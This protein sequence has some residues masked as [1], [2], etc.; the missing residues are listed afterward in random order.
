ME[1]V[2]NLLRSVAISRKSV[3]VCSFTKQMLLRNKY[4]QCVNKSMSAGEEVGKN[5]EIKGEHPHSPA[6]REALDVSVSGDDQ[7]VR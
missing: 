4:W 1:S 7:R 3:I 2:G 5:L 6:Q